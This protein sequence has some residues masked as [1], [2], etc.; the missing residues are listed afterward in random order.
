MTC[1]CQGILPYR[2]HV[3]FTIEKAA[4]GDRLRPDFDIRKLVRA[5]P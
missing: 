3:D 4:S 2:M 1:P 5:I